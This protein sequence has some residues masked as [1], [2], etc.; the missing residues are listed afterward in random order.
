MEIVNLTLP[1]INKFANNY[2]NGNEEI[3][4]Y[5]HYNYQNASHYQERLA[6]LSNRS[7]MRDELVEHIAAFM[8]PFPS[9]VKVEESL[10]KLSKKDAVVVIGGQQAGILTGPLYSIHKVISIIA[11]AKE[12]EQELGVPVVPV[13]WI[14]G[15]DHD[16]AEVNHVFVKKQNQL[17][18][19]VYPY[20]V[21]DKRMV[22]DCKLDK[23]LCK[24]WIEDIVETFG[25]TDF[26]NELLA[27]TDHAL[28][29]SE[30]FVDFF[31]YLVMEMFKE[32]GLLLVDSG[33]RQ[34]RKLEKEILIE[35]INKS[36]EITTAVEA[37]QARLTAKGYSNT[38]EISSQAAN[39]F[40]YD[41]EHY[42][43]ILLEFN[44]ETSIF[45]GKDGSIAFTKDELLLMARENPEKL[46]NNVVTRPL[47]QE[48]L[49]P[50]LAFIAGPGEIAYWSE[51]KTAFELFEMKM[52][53]I[54]PRINITL[55]E[56][57]IDSDLAEL[58]L[59]LQNVLENGVGPEKE[60]FLDSVKD[61]RFDSLFAETKQQL[62]ANYQLIKEQTELEYKGLL[63][64]LEKNESI[65]LTQIGFMEGKFEDALR[66]KHEV[67][68]NKY[69]RV[70]CSLRPSG[71]PQERTWNI[72]YFLNK[73]GLG[74]VDQ[75]T[76]LP[77]QF[78]GKHK[79][80]KI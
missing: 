4:Q 43:R 12:K 15:E 10:E 3:Q 24:S 64:V 35:Q 29:H 54:V 30:N 53:P 58:D 77:Y 6:E 47:M 38:I 73:Y 33:N 69:E 59:D 50:T 62:L 70:E 72:Y 80:V 1:A 60:A 22:T 8:K 45:S 19:M 74:F 18:K 76:N 26:T 49:F 61:K 67:V 66:L 13:F 48:T 68:L 16:Y 75:L 44:P 37:Q 25:E 32:H 52:P 42:E 63:R 31:A 20:K 27:F 7:Y 34:L 51:Y 65:L 21:L 17:E 56:R 9:S 2:Y 55:L 23:E 28:V 36:V 41:E 11:F 5:F 57:D 14:A 39:L 40:Y 71:G 78:D 46:S 79:V